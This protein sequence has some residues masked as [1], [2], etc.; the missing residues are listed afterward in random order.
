M[1]KSLF[2]STA[3]MVC[4]FLPLFTMQG[5]EGQIFG[6]MADTYA[7]ALAGALVLALTIA[8]VL[9]SLL[10][11]NLQ[12]DPRQ[13]SGALR[14]N[15]RYLRQLDVCLTSSLDHAG[16]SWARLIVLTIALLPLLGREFMPELEEG[17]LWIRGTFPLNISLAEASQKA[18]RA[19]AIMQLLA[20]S[21]TSSSAKSAGPTTAPIRR[22]FYNIEF[23]VPLKPRDEWPTVKKGTGWRSW[24]SA[25]A[26]AHQ[27]RTHRGNERRVEPRSLGVNWNFSQNI[28]DNVMESLSGVK[29]DNSVKI[30]GPDL[31]ELEKLA[32]QVKTILEGIRGIHNVGIFRIKGQPNLE[33]PSIRRSASL[34]RQRCRRGERG[35]VGGG[36]QAVL[37]DDRRRKEVR[38]HASLA[39]GLTEQRT[40]RS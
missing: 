27:G 9:C 34:G 11:K 15:A 5:P 22:G 24:F 38:H 23:F 39:R 17:N 35:A 25:S 30:I 31:N 29:G 33:F 36:R 8:P 7:F 21:P 26:T 2:F 37:A 12:A 18:D 14:S 19:R 16:E 4:A 32:A 10:F 3:I 6:P 13:F 40:G 28:R 20:G 1:E